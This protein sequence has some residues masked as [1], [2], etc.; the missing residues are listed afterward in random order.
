VGYDKCL[1]FERDGASF[2]LGDV[3]AEQRAAMVAH[4]DGCAACRRDV[5]ALAT[6]LDSISAAVTPMKPSP[7]FVERVLHAADKATD[8][9]ASRIQ[10]DPVTLTIPDREVRRY[11]GADRP[12]AVVMRRRRTLFVLT[13]STLMLTLLAFAFQAWMVYALAICAAVVAVIYLGLVISITHTKAREDIALA[14]RK[15]EIADDSYWREL[16]PELTTSATLDEGLVSVQPVVAVDNAA[17][18]RF[19]LAYFAGWALTP[20]VA[21]IRLMRGDLAEIEQSPWLAQIVAL[22]RRGRAQSLKLLVAGATTVAVA[23]GGTAATMLISPGMASAAPAT[24]TYTVSA[25][26]TLSAI[27]ARYGV[28]PTYL[29]QLNGISDPNFI[30][31]GEVI[32]LAGGPSATSPSATGGGGTYTV[33]TGD[34]LDA[35]AGRFGA[36]AAEL[37]SINHIIDP[38]LIF[39]GQTLRLTPAAGSGQ[40][41]QPAPS[42]S[43]SYTVQPGDTLAGIAARFG[44]TVAELAAANHIANPNLIEVGQIISLVATPG[45]ASSPS[46][47]SSTAGS[48]PTPATT[49]SAPVSTGYVNPFR[50]GSWSPSRIDEGVDWIPNVTSPVVAIGDGVITYSSMNSGWPAGGFITYRLTS[51]SHA[52]LYIYVAEHITNLLPAGSAVRAGEQIATALPGYP[53]TE[54]GWASPSGPEPAPSARYNG[55]PDGSPTPGGKAFARFLISLGV[56]GIENPGPGPTTP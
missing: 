13:G 34:T 39:V 40:A 33:K 20:V 41:P 18:V 52:G 10:E 4:L 26:D 43:G 56:T 31:P 32:K 55:A 17:L 15:N 42:S 53:W 22:Q 28:S 14:F 5:A 54:W 23:G 16:W 8:I 7:G 2:V 3:P 35:I 29:A 49:T 6:A 24:Q 47:G 19:V 9:A 51:G 1:L 38:N 45:L 11:G 21:L 48:T 44:R 50:F 25:G 30:L 37:A 36:T 12:V 27:A 46:T